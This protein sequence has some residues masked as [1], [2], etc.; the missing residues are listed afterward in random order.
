MKLIAKTRRVGGSL[1]VT[2][3]KTIVQ[4]EGLTEN[5]TIQV[6]IRKIKKS[7]FGISKGKASFSKQDKFKGQLE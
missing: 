7:G 4:E 1:M 6:E 2:I 3:P 5:E